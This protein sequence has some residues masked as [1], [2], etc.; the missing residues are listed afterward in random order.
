MILR[1]W[2]RTEKNNSYDKAKKENDTYISE[3]KN[4]KLST[5]AQSLL[6]YFLY[7]FLNVS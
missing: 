2:V 1:G 6:R 5:S 7:L 4:L 3:R